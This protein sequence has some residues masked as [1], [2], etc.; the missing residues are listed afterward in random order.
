MAKKIRF[1]LE[2]RDNVQVRTLEELQENFSLEKVLFYLD[3]GKLL[4]WLRD[5]Y[6]DE[7][8]DEI[9]KLNLEDIELNRKLCE[10]FDVE[11]DVSL[12]ID[13]ELVAERNRK[14]NLLKEFGY[15]KEDYQEVI[16]QIAFEQ[17]DIYDLLDQKE[18]IIYL[19]GKRFHIP[20][21]VKN[22]EYHGINQPVVVVDSKKEVQWEKLGIFLTGV[23]YDEKY[24]AILNKEENVKESCYKIITRRIE[25]KDFEKYS[26]RSIW[27]DEKGQEFMIF[28]MLI[29]MNTDEIIHH[30]VV[31][32]AEDEENIY[33]L[34]GDLLGVSNYVNKSG[35]Y[36]KITKEKNI[37]SI[38]NNIDD[39]VRFLFRGIEIWPKK[40]D[41]SITDK[42]IY[43][44]KEEGVYQSNH[45]G[46]NLTRIYGISPIKNRNIHCIFINKNLVYY[47]K[48]NGDAK[49]SY[50]MGMYY[51][52]LTICV[53]DT[54]TGKEGLL[55]EKIHRIAIY[56]QF[57]YLMEENETGSVIYQLQIE[58]HKCKKVLSIKEKRIGSFYVRNNYLMYDMT[59][60]KNQKIAEIDAE[61]GILLKEDY[62]KLGFNNSEPKDDFPKEDIEQVYHTELIKGTYCNSL[63]GW[64]NSYADS[65]EIV[66]RC[67]GH[68]ME[69][70]FVFYRKENGIFGRYN[71][72]T[73]ENKILDIKVQYF[74]VKNGIV[75]YRVYK[76]PWS[77]D[78]YAYRNRIFMA[79]YNGNSLGEIAYRFTEEVYD[80]FKYNNVIYI[81]EGLTEKNIIYLAENEQW[82][83]LIDKARTYCFKDNFIYYVNDIILQGKY[84]EKAFHVF[85]RVS[86]ITKEVEKLHEVKF[87]SI[88][89][90]KNGD[91]FIENIRVDDEKIYYEESNHSY[92]KEKVLDLKR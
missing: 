61:Y 69:G 53:F 81:E 28:S 30:E 68:D 84:G 49:S 12:E 8:A 90:L 41:I 43:S 27:K 9:S 24:Q 63:I 39:D 3:N 5:R 19:C 33:F 74:A 18:H 47:A 85:Y 60:R 46:T 40:K 72:E 71:F 58:T 45:D 20:L 17:D 59:D 36:N 65:F 73:K 80:I 57:M 89:G 51:G 16:D 25:K 22:M 91:G 42:K 37:Y 54:T 76:E 15:E 7:I 92:R 6:F 55:H 79:D 88:M 26:V 38:K 82:R 77:S 52:S 29:D 31:E 23:V 48:E 64:K 10:I 1:P 50:F 35:V 87:D 86:T 11:Y 21:S 70:A 34:C 75:Y 13:M 32:F 56:N 83:A 66:E 2:M 4:T 67:Y 14:F 44:F 62:E 78:F